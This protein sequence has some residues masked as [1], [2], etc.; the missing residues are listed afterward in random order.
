MAQTAKIYEFDPVVYPRKLWV[1]VKGSAKDIANT[2]AEPNCGGDCDVDNDDIANS[3]ALAF[4][5]Q[6]K[7][8]KTNGV[9]VWLHSPSRTRIE[10]IA[11]EALHAAAMILNECGV[12]P[13]FDN[14][15]PLAYLVGFCAESIWK[16]KRHEA[17]PKKVSKS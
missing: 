8:E 10:V 2:F 17:E 1:V 5:A 9:V 16:A 12:K 6:N 14:D 11:H 3:D 13:D 7:D 4:S 15:E